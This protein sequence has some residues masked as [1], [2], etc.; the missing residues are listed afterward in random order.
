MVMWMHLGV[1]M[2]LF[3]SC[4]SL[5]HACFWVCDVEDFGFWLFGQNQWECLPKME[6]AFASS[7]GSPCWSDKFNKK[8]H[9]F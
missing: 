9:F 2:L 8:S 5:F 1:V 3:L 7:F 6:E 4:G